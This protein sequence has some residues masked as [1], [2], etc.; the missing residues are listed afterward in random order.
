VI[1]LSRFFKAD[2]AIRTAQPIALGLPR[3]GVAGEAIGEPERLASLAALFPNAAFEEIAGGWPDRVSPNLRILIVAVEGASESS[4]EDAARRLR[5]KAPEL[6]VVVALRDATI[7]NSRRLTREGAADVLP[8]PVSETAL[9]ISL[10]RLLASH[11]ETAAPARRTGQIVSIVKA[12][13]GVGATSLGVQAA[14]IL[15]GRAPERGI[16]FVDLDLQFGTAALYF[17]LA[18][19]LTVADCIDSG[20]ELDGTPFSSALTAHK[21]GVRVLAAP[22]E[23]TALESLTPSMIDGMA[24]GLRRDFDLTVLDLPSVWT[25]WTN[26]ALEHSDRIVL[27]THLSVPHVHLARR[28][29]AALALQKLDAKPLTLVCNCVGADADA[30]ISRRAAERAIGRP[31]DVAIPEDRRAMRSATNQ[32]LQLSDV[33][34]N[35]K[36]EKA[37]TEFADVISAHAFQLSEMRR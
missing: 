30:A 6:N 8:A 28:Q 14:S 19:A 20:M 23:M 3:V 16:G 10:E 36:V 13:G 37:V 11:V 31:F 32:G 1:Q 12:G 2:A 24:A 9:A 26:R 18:D 27:V 34:R 33:G 35:S 4:V 15:A 17:D 22:R 7:A 5:Q 29:L 25:N 21:S